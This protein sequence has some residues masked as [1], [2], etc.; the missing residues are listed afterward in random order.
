MVHPSTIL[1]TVLHKTKLY[2]RSRERIWPPQLPQTHSDPEPTYTQH[3]SHRLCFNP[4]ESSSSSSGESTATQQSFSDALETPALQVDTAITIQEEPPEQPAL[5]PLFA[6]P[7]EDPPEDPNPNPT[8]MTTSAPINGGGALRGTPPNVFNGD[9]SKSDIFWNEFWRYKLLNRNNDAMSVPFSRVLTALSYIRGPLVDDWVGAQDR[10]LERCLDSRR[11][12]YVEDTNEILW[13]EFETAFRSA[14]KDGEKKQSAYEQLMKL[15][16]KDLDIDSYAATFDRLAAAAGWEPDAG[17]TIERFAR[18]LRD[19]IH[20]RILSQD[21]EPTTMAECQEAARGEVHKVRK[22]IG[23]GLDFRNKQ[24]PRDHGPFQTGQ[25]Q[26]TNAPRP[27]SNSGIVP[28]EVD[29]TTT[30][31][32]FKKLTDDEREQYRKEG[33]CFRCRQKGHLARECAG[34]PP[35]I[36]PT[37]PSTV[38]ARTTNDTAAAVNLTPDDS[39]SNAPAARATTITAKLTLAQQIAKLEEQMSDDERSAYLDARL[40]DS[41]FYDVG[42]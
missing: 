11:I 42:Q 38:S 31:T 14:W 3:P 6:E 16:M 24:K 30:R 21:K 41:D 15:T 10:R 12:D 13:T 7:P 36:P 40:M 18:G 8:A 35:Q 17:G 33:R 2:H 1:R 34:R 32:P 9:R 26:R 4:D 5:A 37:P 25:T 22:I 27:N 20:R 28:M 29:A 23:A 39:V 19:N